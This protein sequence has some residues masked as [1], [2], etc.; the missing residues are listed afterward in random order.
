VKLRAAGLVPA[1]RI[2]CDLAVFLIP[3]VVYIA[4]VSH[5]PASWDTAELQSVP[6]LL[7]IS[8]PT[9]FPLF[10]LLGF[11][12]SHALSDGTVAFRMNVFS[13]LTIAGAVAAAYAVALQLGARRAFALPAALW[14]AFTQDV[15]S[16]AIR[17][18]AQ[19]LAVMCEALAIYAFVRW[20]RGGRD[21]WYA[22][23]F[24]LLGLGMAAHPNAIWLFPGLVVGSIVAA[25]RPT[26][27]LAAGSLA[28]TFAALLLYLYVP[29][30]SMYV[31]AHGLDPTHVLIG[32]NGG[33]FWNY[34]NPSTPHGLL[35]AMT[36]AESGT[37][38]SFLNS[39]NPLHTQDALWAFVQGVGQE[40][41]AFALVLGFAGAFYGWKRDW[42]TTLFLCVACM[43]SLLFSVTYTLESD[44]G[45][46]RLLALWLEV[47][48]VAS[49]VAGPAAGIG[50]AIARVALFIF[51]MCGATVTFSQHTKFFDRDPDEG[52][53]WVID[54]VEPFVPRGGVIVADWLDA[55][56]LAYGAYV[57]GS[58]GGRIVVSGVN[59]DDMGEM[60]QWARTRPVYI[61]VNPK[62]DDKYPGTEPPIKIDDYHDLL[63]V[64]K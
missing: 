31:V 32:T 26:W 63:E 15:W 6:Y 20:L 19:D 41:G 58:L 46:Y 59:P 23:A 14:Y 61:L 2:A 51:L 49:L 8:H 17:A 18:E 16:H 7:G 57:D 29:L 54:A 25:R 24:L 34:D 64:R 48:L 9:G 11:V 10:V 39:F 62:D 28:L 21:R 36:G 40:F 42:R 12:W 55:T 38:G 30:R 33:L 56:S 27:R 13:A 50:V 52:G 22:A 4:S 1:A 3:A 53:R 60:R 35:L 43:A 5:E 45:R 44:I 37:P 47:P